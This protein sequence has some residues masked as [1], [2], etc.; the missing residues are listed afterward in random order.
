MP[1]TAIKSK[2]DL[3]EDW[4]ERTYADPDAISLKQKSLQTINFKVGNF[5]DDERTFEAVASTPVVDRQGDVIQQDGW[6]LDNFIKCPV[7]PLF[8]NYENFPVARAIEVGVD[9]DGL[10][11]FVYQA[12]PEGI[13]PEADLAWNYYRNQ[14][15]FAFS[16]G[17][18]PLESEGNTFTKCELLEISAVVVPANPQALALAYKMGIGDKDSVNKLI[19]T[20]NAAIKALE[21]VMEMENKGVIESD[22]PINDDKTA[23]WSAADAIKRIEDWATVDGKTNFAKLQKCFFWKDPQNDN[24]LAGYK[25]PFADIIDGSPKAIWR[26]VTASMA[27]LN[28]ARGGVKIP[29]TD[30]EPVYNQIKKYYTKFGE[31]APDLAKG[32]DGGIV[33]SAM[34]TTKLV[35]QINDLLEKGAVSDELTDEQEFQA[36]VDAMQP[37]FQVWEAFMNTVFSN[38]TKAEQLPDLLNETI[39]LLAKCMG[40]T[41]NSLTTAGIMGENEDMK[42]KAGA[43]ISSANKEKLASV[44]DYLLKSVEEAAKHIKTLGEML[45]LPLPDGDPENE[46]T[47]D[48]NPKNENEDGEKGMSNKGEANLSKVKGADQQIDLDTDIDPDNLTVE[49]AEFIAKEFNKLTDESEE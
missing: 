18:I 32:F 3:K 24:V 13:N 15:M 44:H 42:T 22:L 39:G 2:P 19:T 7:I 34:K 46:N 1:V 47:P 21:E 10:L 29:D 35:K 30:K 5:N 23:K 28:G 41:G 25:L 11:K 8:H 43:T 31:K 33:K 9:T 36:K 37:V 20:T 14:F 45:D 27:A 49:Q 38:D 26:G 48:D 40:E 12:P 17:F 6:V 16:V 4:Y